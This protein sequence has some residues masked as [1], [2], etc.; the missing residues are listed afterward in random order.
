M[1]GAHWGGGLPFYATMPEIT[2]AFANLRVDTAASSLLYDGTIYARVSSLVGSGAILFGS[3]YPL[4][5]QA[6]SRRRIE[7]SGLPP[8]DV[9]RILG[10]NAAAFL[11]LE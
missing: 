10:D 2:S 5:S 11:G 6:R 7:D 8:E 3:D 4:L 1:I 9:S